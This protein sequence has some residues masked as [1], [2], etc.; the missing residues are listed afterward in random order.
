MALAKGIYKKKNKQAGAEQSQAQ[1]S[2][3]QLPAC[4]CVASFYWEKTLSGGWGW[5]GR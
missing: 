1:T 3:G 5:V 2:L 4:F